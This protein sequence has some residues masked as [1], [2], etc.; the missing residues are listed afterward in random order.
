MKAV[1]LAA[2]M[3]KRLLPFTKTKP[4]CLLEFGGKSLLQRYWES[5]TRL[6]VQQVVL[7]IGYKGE[8]V[9][10]AVQ[11]FPKPPEVMWVINADFAR[12]S[13]GSLWA[14]KDE[15]CSDD[16]LIMDADVLFPHTLLERLVKSPHP[17]ALLL[18]ETVVQQSE[19]CMAAVKQDRVIA[20]S[21]RL[22]ADY[23]WAGEGVGFLKVGREA[24]PRLVQ[25]IERVIHAGQINMEYEDALQEFFVSTPVGYE[26]IGGLPWI[27]IDFP[28]DMWRAETEVL[29]KL[30]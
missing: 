17:N 7:V 28:V 14:A 29:P 27:E 18:D 3:G 25:S 2:G 12:G 5:L 9:Q 15:F 11:S 30:A 19:E 23:D 24:L 22:P 13:V 4:K 21:K 1:I 16:V 20:L 10:E 6:G 26:K 8:M